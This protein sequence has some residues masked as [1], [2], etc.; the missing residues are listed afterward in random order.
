MSVEQH[1]AEGRRHLAE[2]RYE[3]AMKAY[4]DAVL[5]EPGS[6]VAMVNLLGLKGLRPDLDVPSVVARTVAFVAPDNPS[7]L[8]NHGEILRA[9]GH[10]RKAMG[11][12]RRSLAVRPGAR[13]VW[14]K[15]AVAQEQLQI[16][17]QMD[18]SLRRAYSIGPGSNQIIHAL[19]G[20]MLHRKQADKALAFLDEASATTA[21]N[22]DRDRLRIRALIQSSRI[23][24]ALELVDAALR[25][26]P[27]DQGLWVLRALGQRNLGRVDGSVRDGRRALLIQPDAA[28]ALN[29][30]AMTMLRGDRLIEGLACLRHHQVSHPD[31]AL[32]SNGLVG[33]A[34]VELGEAEAGIQYLRKGCVA[35]PGQAETLS[36]LCAAYVTRQELDK[37]LV[38]VRRGRV[39]TQ[40][41]ADLI[42]NH[43]LVERF[44]GRIDSALINLKAAMDLKPDDPVYHFT[45]SLLELGDG[46]PLVGI[47][48]HRHRWR[49]PKFSAVRRMMPEPGLPVPVWDGRRLT[50]TLALWGEQGVGDE[51]WFSGY[52]QH[53]IDLA[54]NVLLEVSPHMVKLMERSFPNITV[55]PR[56]ARE[57]EEMLKQADAQR[58]LGDLFDLFFRP[59]DLVPS[60]YLKTDLSLAHHLRA[61][62]LEGTEA[63]TRLIGISWQSRKRIAKRSFTAP[64]E[65]WG[66]VLSLSTDEAIWGRQPVRFV[67]LQYG[68][69]TDDVET[70][71][72]LFGV[73][74]LSDPEVDPLKDLDAAA[75]QVMAM[76]GVLSVANATVALAHALGRHCAVAA[77][78]DQDD[79]RYP[80]L[81]MQSRW[82]P[83]ISHFWQ[84]APQDWSDALKGAARSVA[85]QL[86]RTPGSR[87][88]PD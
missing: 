71:R 58:P 20:L 24:E 19:V 41:S 56:H 45:G 64:I 10:P 75:A 78:I 25:D 74:I 50:G 80:R 31:Q 43:A 63:G 48:H 81:S 73:R 18:Q 1:L 69:V 62:Y 83:N 5:I 13:N 76:D 34:L 37:A 26:N 7:V 46:D 32:R 66:A 38:A 14:L 65:Q 30:H 79:W 70:A 39:I 68:D 36:N 49:M 54:D 85:E 72:R 82:L 16:P 35:N 57:T 42:Y 2:K 27:L 33:S 77:R 17:E 3:L 21:P 11:W 60:G 53:A 9:E 67:S 52:I 59:E 40:D 8:Y 22:L 6:V 86:S 88:I 55:L 87:S 51:L 44:S 84:T 29:Q 23:D 12:F 4:R 61:R 47:S 28:K 15:L